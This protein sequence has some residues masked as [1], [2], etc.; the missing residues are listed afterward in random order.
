VPKVNPIAGADATEP[1]T[2]SP[3]VP[4]AVTAPSWNPVSDADD[5][6]MYNSTVNYTLQ[7]PCVSVCVRPAV[8]KSPFHATGSART[9][10]GLFLLLVRRCGTHCPKTCGIQSVLWTVTDSHWRHFYFC[11]TSVFS[12]LEVGYDN[13]LYKFMTFDICLS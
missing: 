8:I 9:A 10:V 2:G 5:V 13:A 3:D 7:L 11:S 6:P 1:D 4:T 12:A